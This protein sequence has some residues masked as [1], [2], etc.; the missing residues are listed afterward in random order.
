[1]PT[2]IACTGSWEFRL[3]STAEPIDTAFAVPGYCHPAW[4]LIDV[5]SASDASGPWDAGLSGV[6]PWTGLYRRELHAPPGG[7]PGWSLRLVG[8]GPVPRLWWDGRETGMAGWSATIA[9]PASGGIALVA[10]AITDHPRR[11]SPLRSI[12]L[13]RSR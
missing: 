2:A 1:M 6:G 11:R 12:L 9:C 5:P 3:Q 4:G 10:L 13:A 8:D 7:W